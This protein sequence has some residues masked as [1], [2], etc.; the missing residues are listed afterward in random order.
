MKRHL[1]KHEKEYQCN[2]QNCGY[3]NNR[4]DGKDFIYQFAK[5]I[6]I[7]KLD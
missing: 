7:I 3:G 5:K 1:W 2:C 4:K 6:L